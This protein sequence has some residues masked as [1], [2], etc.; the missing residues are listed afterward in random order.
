MA[1]SILWLPAHMAVSER[2]QRNMGISRETRQ[3]EKTKRT[4]SKGHAISG[5]VLLGG[6]AGRPGGILKVVVNLGFHDLSQGLL[7]H[8]TPQGHKVTVL[9]Q[10][11]ISNSGPPFVFVWLTAII[12][13]GVDIPICGSG[14][15]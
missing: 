15:K 2:S 11:K 7:G 12:F 1:Q 9:Q 14:S 10:I 8:E 3:K 13:G 5:L 6:H 4:Q